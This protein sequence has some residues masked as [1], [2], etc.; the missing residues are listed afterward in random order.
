MLIFLLREENKLNEIASL[1]VLIDS[2]ECN[3]NFRILKLVYG[4]KF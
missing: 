4:Y 3:Q 2:M 1:K